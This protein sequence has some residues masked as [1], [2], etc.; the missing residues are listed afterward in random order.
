[1]RAE[2]THKVVI[3]HLL[4][5]KSPYCSLEVLKTSNNA[6]HWAAY[7]ISDEKPQPEKF[8]G[9]FTSKEEYERFEKEFNNACEVNEKLFSTETKTEIK[10][11]TKTEAPAET[12]TETKAEEKEETKTETTVAEETKPAAE[13]KKE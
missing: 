7:D 1:M 5:K 10:T 12:K 9:K 11:E 8:A 13:E 2:K 3:N 6:W 4:Q